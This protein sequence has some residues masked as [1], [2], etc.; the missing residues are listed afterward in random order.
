MEKAAHNAAEYGLSELGVGC[1][2]PGYYSY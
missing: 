2:G 1:A